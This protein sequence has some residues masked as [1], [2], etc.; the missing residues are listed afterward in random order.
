MN[1]DPQIILYPGR[2]GRPDFALRVEGGTVWLTQA[3]TAELFQTTTPNI[4]IH[5]HIRNILKE[6]ELES[7]AVI[8]ES[9]ITAADGKNYWTKLYRLEMILAVG[10]R[11]RSPRGTEFRQ[12]AT[13]HLSEYLVKG[14]VMNDEVNDHIENLLDMVEIDSGSEFTCRN[15]FVE[16]TNMVG[17]NSENL[18]RS[19]NCRNG[20]GGAARGGESDIGGG[21]GEFAFG[22]GGGTR[23]RARAGFAIHGPIIFISAAVMAGN[24]AIR[25][26]GGTRTR[27]RAGFAIHGPIKSQP[28]ARPEPFARLCRPVGP[29]GGCHCAPNGGREPSEGLRGIWMDHDWPME[30]QTRCPGACATP[31]AECEFPQTTP[32][33]R[34][35]PACATP[36][37]ECMMA[38]TTRHAAHMIVR[39][40]FDTVREFPQ[41]TP[42]AVCGIPH[43]GNEIRGNPSFIPKHIVHR[44][45]F[46]VFPTSRGIHP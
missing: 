43:H 3:E 15:H 44:I 10:Y 5:I 21:F 2:S 12:W 33:A 9:L 26:G 20:I 23:T 41:T 40:S 17:N 28:A 16:I 11:V 29:V 8:K 18:A 34:L 38:R 30:R 27:A 35:T 42:S 39:T 6:R 1:P 36:D 37:M 7:D 45:R 13:A 24:R 25:A 4:N 14:F 19:G 32:D 31:D 46:R 22:V